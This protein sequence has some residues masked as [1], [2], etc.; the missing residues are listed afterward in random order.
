MNVKRIARYLNC[1]PIAK[2]LIEINTFTQ[3]VSC[4]QTATGQ[5]NT[6]RSRAQAVELR[7]GATRLC[8]H[9]QEH[10]NQ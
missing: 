3:Y 4:T 1:V 10:N 7:S 5:D 2:C 9:G 6:K 8:L